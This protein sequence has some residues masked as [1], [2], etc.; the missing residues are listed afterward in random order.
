MTI[1][2]EVHS[3]DQELGDVSDDRSQAE[4]DAEDLAVLRKTNILD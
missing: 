4:I 3:E 2:I 1:T